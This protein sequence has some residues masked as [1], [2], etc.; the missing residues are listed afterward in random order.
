MNFN[1]R[2]NNYRKKRKSYEKDVK[3]HIKLIFEDLEEIFSNFKHLEIGFENGFKKTIDYNF[4]IDDI[5]IDIIKLEFIKKTDFEGDT[6]LK[7]SRFL[8]KYNLKIIKYE[9][10]GNRLILNINVEG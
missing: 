7:I 8:S 10:Y 1:I 9:L 6:F 2:Y 5:D 4:Y 3:N